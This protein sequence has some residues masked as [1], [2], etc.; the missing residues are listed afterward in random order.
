MESAGCVDGGGLAKIGLEVGHDA[1]I[2][3]AVARFFVGEKSNRAGRILN[4]RKV[5]FSCEGDGRVKSVTGANKESAGGF[6]GESPHP[7][8]E[9]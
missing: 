2:D 5:H 8:C 1:G 3:F 4:F 6:D 7:T 9:T